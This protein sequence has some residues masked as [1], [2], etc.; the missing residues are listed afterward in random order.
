MT[1]K[2]VRILMTADA[3]GGV[4]TYTL[5]LA[6]ALAVSSVQLGIAVMGS[7]LSEQ[8]RK[9]ALAL[10]NVEI[11][12]S[13]FKLEWMEDPWCD[14]QQAGDWLLDIEARFKPDLVHLNGYVHA[15]LPW[16][17]PVILVGHSCVLSWWK[18]VRGDAPPAGLWDRYCCDV[19]RGLHAADLVVAPTRAMLHSLSEFYGLPSATRVIPNGRSAGLFQAAAKY[20]F[21]ISAGRLWDDAKNIAAL[22]SVVTRLG[23]PV[24]VAGEVAAPDGSCKEWAA[25]RLLGRLNT[26]ELARWYSHAS[27]FAEPARYEPFGLSI[28]EAALSGCALV[29]GDIPSLRETW[30]GAALFVDPDDA[31]ELEWALRSFIGDTT[32]RRLA[33]R[34]ART[35]ALELSSDRMAQAYLEAYEALCSER[36][37]AFIEVH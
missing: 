29:L 8:Q 32:E 9:D 31:R 23:W 34:R 11:F 26:P 15:A 12:E 30:E 1:D 5:E 19:A 17:A 36:R 10:P 14:V 25:L 18:A 27:I 7:R 3:L 16:S 13:T 28:L 20:P 6:N 37:I 2:N 22:N 21:V 24:Y 4:W 33:A 35:R